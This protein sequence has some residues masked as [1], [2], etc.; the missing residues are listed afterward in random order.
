MP[1]R[2]RS[3]RSSPAS[4]PGQF[5]DQSEDEEAEYPGEEEVFDPCG[6]LPVEARSALD[7]KLLGTTPDK[8]T[9]PVDAPVVSLPPQ[10]AS[11]STALVASVYSKFGPPLDGSGDHTIPPILR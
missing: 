9:D 1:T 3:G 11:A 7:H 4:S 8:P 2:T 5:S 6:L 10:T